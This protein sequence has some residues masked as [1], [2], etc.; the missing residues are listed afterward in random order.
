MANL[1]VQGSLGKWFEF[2]Q[3]KLT[4][5]R[6]GTLSDKNKPSYSQILDVC[7][8]YKTTLYSETHLKKFLV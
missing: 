1:N 7:K 8:M 4:F 3:W 5:W 6:N 2:H